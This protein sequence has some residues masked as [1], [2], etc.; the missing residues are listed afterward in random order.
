MIV[1]LLVGIATLTVGLVWP[2]PYIATPA[3]EVWVVDETGQPL[4]S[5]TV[6]LVYQ[7]H[8]SEETRHEVDALTDSL[9]HVQ[10]LEQRS[11]AS[12][13]R[14]LVYSVRSGMAGIHASFG[15][16]AGVFAFGHGRQGDSITGDILTDWTGTP[17]R[18]SSRIVAKL[19]PPI[20][21]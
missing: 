18:M 9:G 3:W 19:L 10:F 6:R 14:Y 8:S 17:P 21:R 2:I 7:N 16:H 1:A 4:E 20:R 11:S 15:R 5:M 12:V 13:A